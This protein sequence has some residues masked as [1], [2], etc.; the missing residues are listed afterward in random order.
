MVDNALDLR[1]AKQNRVECLAEET[2]KLLC[3]C[4]TGI[5]MISDKIIGLTGKTSRQEEIAWWSQISKSANDVQ[6]EIAKFNDKMQTLKN[7]FEEKFG[8]S[9][10][11]KATEK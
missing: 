3:W 2:A 6:E 1:G 5:K 10:R 9:S 8:L 4:E 7:Y 11:R